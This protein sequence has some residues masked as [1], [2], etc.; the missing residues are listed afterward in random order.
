MLLNTFLSY[1]RTDGAIAKSI[2]DRVKADVIN[3]WWDQEN[4]KGRD[5]SRQLLI[6]IRQSRAVVLLVSRVSVGSI[7]VKREVLMADAYRRQILPVYLAAKQALLEEEENG[8]LILIIDLDRINAYDGRDPIPELL[9]ALRNQPTQTTAQA[10]V[11][12][13]SQEKTMESGGNGWCGRD[14]AQGAWANHI[15]PTPR[16]TLVQQASHVACDSH[17]SRRRRPVGRVG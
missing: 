11:M 10:D 15:E 1:S 17:D 14:G 3:V 16:H 13:R 12:A 9:Q 7:W 2:H 6:W 5:F 4:L 8:L